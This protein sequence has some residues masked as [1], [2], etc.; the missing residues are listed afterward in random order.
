MLLLHKSEPVATSVLSVRVSANERALLEAAAERAHT[1]L[2]DF[3]R[4][5]ALETAELDVLDQRG[6]VIPA[7]DWERFEAWL[8]KPPEAIPALTELSGLRPSWEE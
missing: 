8:R 6:A 2:S 3:I 1:S 5:T 7:A 4:R